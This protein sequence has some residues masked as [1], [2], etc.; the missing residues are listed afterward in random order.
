MT[1]SSPSHPGTSLRLPSIPEWKALV[2]SFQQP[3]IPR[4]VW[5]MVNT[6]VPYF[7]LWG[8]MIW[9]LSG[10]Y[11]VT[12]LLAFVAGLFLIRIFI[13]FHDC[14]HG[15]F[16]KSRTANNIVGFLTGVLTFTPFLHW[17]WEH[18]VHHNSCGDLDRRGTGDIWTMTVKE[19]RE[20][21]PWRR[22]CYH[23]AR[24]PIV[25]F[26]IAPPLLFFFYQLIPKK[27]A[28]RK[29]K[30]SVWWMNLALLVVAV[31]MSYAIGW[32]E[33]LLIQVPTTSI[34][35]ILGVWMFY[36][37]HQFEDVTWEHHE[38]WDFT[39]AAL[40]GSSFYKLPKVL[41]WFT[42]NI[43][44]HHIHHLSAR[45]PNYN[46]ERCHNSHE[47]FKQVEPITILSSLRTIRLRLWDEDSKRLVGYDFL[48][49]NPPPASGSDAS[50]SSG[51]PLS[52]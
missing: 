35:C 50:S 5:Q 15:S 20:A 7:A 33:Y 41:Q 39:Q 52:A 24:N 14:G 19:Y 45:I 48:K 47:I 36:V 27:D 26:L 46:L 40:Q 4:A 3:S 8:L 9:S 17:R 2:S 44:F 37:Q 30:N 18:N 21:T 31:A 32:K 43:G 28:S 16:F 25:L 10:P 29:E 13:I 49:K 42:G 38:E 51:A 1:S 23:I 12:L 11:W 34:T 6:L 22:V